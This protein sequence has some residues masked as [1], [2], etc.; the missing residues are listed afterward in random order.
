[1]KALISALSGVAREACRTA[2]LVIC[3]LAESCIFFIFCFPSAARGHLLSPLSFSVFTQ[4]RLSSVSVPTQVTPKH[5]QLPK[6]IFAFAN[7]S[8]TQRKKVIPVTSQ[9]MRALVSCI[10]LMLNAGQ[11][12]SSQ[13]LLRAW[14]K[15]ELPMRDDPLPIN[16]LLAMV[17][18]ALEAQ[19][20]RIAMSLLIGFSRSLENQ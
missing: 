14:S 3:A 7:S 16:F 17:G 10:S 13:R 9:Q 1:M 19:T 11:I 4:L 5:T 8:S 20:L 18:A 15:H 2:A 6:W 12:H